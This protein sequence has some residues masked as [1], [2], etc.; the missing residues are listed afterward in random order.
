MSFPGR[1]IKTKDFYFKN[2]LTQV[3]WISNL[4]VV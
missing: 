4:A 2:S 3:V 1:R